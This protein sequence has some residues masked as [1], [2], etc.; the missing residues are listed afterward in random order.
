MFIGVL[1]KENEIEFSEC[2]PEGHYFEL[3]TEILDSKTLV[4][5]FNQINHFRRHFSF[6]GDHFLS[7]NEHAPL[8]LSMAYFLCSSMEIC[9]QFVNSGG[10]QQIEMF[11][12][13]GRPGFY[14]YMKF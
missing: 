4:D 9:F 6:I 14:Y 2:L 3:E 7:Q 12:F 5:M 13:E 10:R 1:S 11:F 8:G